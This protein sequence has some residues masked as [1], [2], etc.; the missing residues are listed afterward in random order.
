MIY[1]YSINAS[2][3]LMTLKVDFDVGTDIRT[4]TRS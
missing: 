2:N 4:P 1:M 3:G